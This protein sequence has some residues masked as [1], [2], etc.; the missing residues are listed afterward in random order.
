MRS[1]TRWNRV[2]YKEGK[3]VAK[4]GVLEQIRAAQSPGKGEEERVGHQRR[5]MPPVRKTKAKR[6]P[7]RG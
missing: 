4:A 2:W 5:Q 1:K 7:C 6:E 3:G